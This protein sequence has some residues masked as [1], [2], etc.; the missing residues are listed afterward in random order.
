MRQKFV[1]VKFIV[2]WISIRS[3]IKQYLCSKTASSLREHGLWKVI[4][5]KTLGH[6][7]RLTVMEVYLEILD[8]DVHLYL[9]WY[10][11][12]IDKVKY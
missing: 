10:S 1:P 7:V 4:L 6:G 2:E 8:P 9:L 11:D 3:G 5:L 12:S